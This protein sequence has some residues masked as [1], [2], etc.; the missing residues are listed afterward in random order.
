MVAARKNRD[1]PWLMRTYSGHSS[2][3]ASNTLYRTNL[4]KGQTGLSV[5]FD[6]PTQTGYDADSPLTQRDDS[7]DMMLLRGVGLEPMRI[8]YTETAVVIALVHVMLPFMVIPVWTSL[9]KLDA[10]VENAALSLNASQFTTLRR[11]VLPQVLPGV[12]SGSLI[13]FGLSASAFA[14][15]VLLGGRRL[16]MVA[17]VVYDEYLHELNWPLGATIAL[18]LLLANLAVMLSYNRVVEGSYKKSLG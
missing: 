9:Q 3:K 6:L 14:I 7:D 16:K 17:T 18:L 11:V 10:G 4:A 15:P 1:Q 13:V 2:A 5:A 8:L 12:L